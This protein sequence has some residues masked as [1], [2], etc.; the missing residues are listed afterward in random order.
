MDRWIK[1]KSTSN[2][3]C[4]GFIWGSQYNKYCGVRYINFM[5]IEKYVILCKWEA[6]SKFVKTVVKAHADHGADIYVVTVKIEVSSHLI[7]YIK[8]GRDHYL[9]KKYR[10]SN[11]NAISRIKVI[12]QFFER[13]GLRN[14]HKRIEGIFCGAFLD[15]ELD[16][17]KDNDYYLEKPNALGLYEYEVG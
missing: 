15:E 1:V 2:I 5:G 9:L 10:Y 14:E 16:E 12:K 11:E 7:G 8:Y 6:P 3:S 17:W 13:L 4:R